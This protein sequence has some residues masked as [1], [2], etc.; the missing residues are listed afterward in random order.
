LVLAK[1]QIKKTLK[2]SFLKPFD[3]KPCAN[4]HRRSHLQL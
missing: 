1:E 4:L 2:A 3:L